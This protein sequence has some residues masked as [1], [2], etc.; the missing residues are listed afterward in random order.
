MLILP[1][2]EEGKKDDPLN[3]NEVSRNDEHDQ[4]ITRAEIEQNDPLISEV[5]IRHQEERKHTKI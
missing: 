1:P 4:E 3:L 5:N 2:E